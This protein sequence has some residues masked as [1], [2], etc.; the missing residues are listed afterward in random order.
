MWLATP[1][2][3][4]RALLQECNN[5]KGNVSPGNGV[6]DQPVSR[7]MP[8][9]DHDSSMAGM[10]FM[11][12]SRPLFRRGMRTARATKEKGIGRNARKRWGMVVVRVAGGLLSFE[13]S[14]A[15]SC[16]FAR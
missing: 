3:T 15:L 10:R 7:T 12:S 13:R 14:E 16:S 1:L 9:A 2:S 8:T 4:E 6:P 11:I 5:V